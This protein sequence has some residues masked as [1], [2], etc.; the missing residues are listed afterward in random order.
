VDV[1]DLPARASLTAEA[2][3]VAAAV[4][5][6]VAL[7]CGSGGLVADERLDD[8][9]VEVEPFEGDGEERGRALAGVAAA[10]EPLAEPDAEVAAAGLPVQVDAART[11]ELARTRLALARSNRVG[12]VVARRPR[13][14][15]FVEE[16][17]RLPRRPV[18]V[19]R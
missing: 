14:G 18:G 16:D 9:E 1:L 8:D 3:L 15:H 5:D 6:D 12:G 7:D 13:L 4:G 11:G 10:L 19:P 2:T 17:C